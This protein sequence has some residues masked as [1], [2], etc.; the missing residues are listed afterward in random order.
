MTSRILIAAALLTV[1]WATTAPRLTAQERDTTGIAEF[2]IRS[3]AVAA[4]LAGWFPFVPIGH[5]YAGDVKRGLLP[6]GTQVAG[7]IMALIGATYYVG[8]SQTDYTET[9]ETVAGVGAGSG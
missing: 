2:Q 5:V 1:L 7:G 4:L 6:A 8:D 3:P 9:M